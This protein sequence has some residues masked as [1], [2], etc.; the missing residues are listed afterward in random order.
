M[1]YKLRGSR[2]SLRNYRSNS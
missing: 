2:E 1:N